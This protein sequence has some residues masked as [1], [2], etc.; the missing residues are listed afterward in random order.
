M[1]VYFS[2][3][4]SCEIVKLF[5]NNNVVRDASTSNHSI[6][7]R[8]SQQMYLSDSKLQ[9]KC[10]CIDCKKMFT[11][12]GIDQHFHLMHTEMGIKERAKFHYRANQQKADRIAQ[13][14]QNPAL[15]QQ[16]DAAMEYRKRKNKFCSSS[17]AA[18]HN[19]LLHSPESRKQQIEKASKTLKEHFSKNPRPKKIREKT[20]KI[21]QPIVNKTKKEV[22]KK[23]LTLCKIS[24]CVVCHKCIPNKHQRTCS[25]TCFRTLASQR[26]TNRLKDPDFRKNYGRQKRSYL[27]ES[28]SKWLE[29]N[30]VPYE[31]EIQ[32]KNHELNKYYYAD[33][34]FRDLKLIIELDGTQHR[35]TVEQDRIRDEYIKKTYGYDVFRVTHA[36]YRAKNKYLT[37]CELL[38]I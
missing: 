2:I 33:F 31:Y 1:A 19:N 12:G 37:I 34:V 15:C 8:E 32:F 29:A 13:Y 3:A 4:V 11:I 16:C 36:E 24:F 10:S 14:N 25:N 9:G 35:K 30:A 22:K 17:C 27:E 28:F 21:K 20:P 26:M 38:G 6:T 7:S 23:E 18:S 5:I